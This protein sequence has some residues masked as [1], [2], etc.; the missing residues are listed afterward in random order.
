L[1]AD[2]ALC[3]AA[4]V[5]RVIPLASLIMAVVV[6]AVAGPARA[7]VPER[8]EATVDF[9]WF[10]GT[11]KTDDVRGGTAPATLRVEANRA[12][13]ASVGVVEEF[14]GGAGE[15]WRSTA[16][17]AA[18]T[19]AG[20][21]RQSFLANE[22]TVRTGGHVDGPS[23]GML[24]TA[25]FLALLRGV[26]VLP[27]VTMTGT[28]NP[29]GTTGPVGGIP[30]KLQGAAAQG[31]KVFGYPV[32]CRQTEDLKTGRVIDIEALGQQ[33]GV[34]TVEV[35]TL[36][37]AYLLLTGQALE[38]RPALDVAALKASP[39][40]IETTR[41]RVDMWRATAESAFG[42]VQPQLNAMDNA[43]RQSLSWIYTPI[44]SAVQQATAYE[45]SGQLIAAEKKWLE[46]AVATAAAE[47]SLAI[48]KAAQAGKL[49]EAFAVLV[50][51]LELEAQATAMLAEV[52]QGLAGEGGASAGDAVSAVNAVL[53]VESI[54]DALALVSAGKGGL[55]QAVDLAKQL[56]TSTDAA[57]TQEKVRAFFMVLL[58]TAP[59]LARAE[60]TLAAARMDIAF[61]GAAEQGGA[62]VQPTTLQALA[63]GYA[64]A[65][66]A[67][68]SY[69]QALV[70]LDDASSAAFSFLEPGWA[71]ASMGTQLAAGFSAKES[72]LERIIALAAGAEA[73][74]SAAALQNKYYAL[75]YKS[76]VIGRR[77]A[78]TAQLTAA[79][80]GALVAAAAVKAATGVVPQ[81]IVTEFNQAEELRE[82]SDDDKID[83]LSAYWRASFA[84]ELMAELTRVPGGPTP[85]PTAP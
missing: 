44:F 6:V 58:K 18:F 27:G 17:I 48:V 72:D 56:E 31:K 22:F 69:F 29:D 11:P 47:D 61:G 68:K 52:G 50:P 5:L 20:R 83:A 3:D 10:A 85:T 38:E 62:A 55:Q 15:Q 32:G 54:V 2:R 80:E 9:V 45:K 28:I 84:A 74:L 19:A 81:R 70:G 60:S 37:D 35:K 59:V 25:T 1:S 12:P 64:S 26:P 21:A 57:Q 46:V 43:T 77:A 4:S 8:R 41:I 39:D 53:S 71:T 36:A 73:Y 51:Y 33:L 76:G 30:Q 42:R 66:S 63:R 23:A 14:A 34:Q 82:G 16:W 78:L 40:L 75:E 67:G 49:D 7:Q 24:T 79:R 65:A 13:G